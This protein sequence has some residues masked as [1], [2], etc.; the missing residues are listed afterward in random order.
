MNT[1]TAIRHLTGR[2]LLAGGLTVALTSGFL[3]TLVAA[4]IASS[5]ASPTRSGGEDPGP[6]ASST[7]HLVGVVCFNIPHQWNAALEGPLPQCY[8]SAR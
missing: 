2:T 3:A 4:T 5:A 7:S 8:R 1:S 6:G